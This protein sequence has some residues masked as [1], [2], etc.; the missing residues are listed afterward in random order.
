MALLEVPTVLARRI[1]PTNLTSVGGPP[2][3]KSITPT[4]REWNFI[5]P[6]SISVLTSSIAYRWFHVKVCAVAGV[7]FF[8]DA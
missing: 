8:T 4:F 5:D 1:L 7:G 6:C 2:Y 3:L